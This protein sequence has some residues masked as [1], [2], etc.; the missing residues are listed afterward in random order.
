MS[1]NADRLMNVSDLAGTVGFH[2]FSYPIMR[3]GENETQAVRKKLRNRKK[4]GISE[5][6]NFRFDDNFTCAFHL[7]LLLSNKPSLFKRLKRPRKKSFKTGVFIHRIPVTQKFGIR[8]YVEGE[9]TDFKGVFDTMEQA[10]IVQSRLAV[11]LD[12]AL[13]TMPV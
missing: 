9:R 6:G 1:L 12:Y 13:L 11:T 4:C 2:Y 8:I 7:N 3:L 10:V 5:C